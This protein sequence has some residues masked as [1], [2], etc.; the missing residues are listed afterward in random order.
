MRRSVRS[1]ALCNFAQ[2]TIKTAPFKVL[3][4]T[5]MHSHRRNILLCAVVTIESDS[6]VAAAAGCEAG[7]DMDA[8]T[9]VRSADRY[10]TLQVIGTP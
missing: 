4:Q 8:D 5:H 6:A 10:D 2:R 3:L 9:A 7:Q 1:C